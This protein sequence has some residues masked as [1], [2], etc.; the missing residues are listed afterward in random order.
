MS[1]WYSMNPPRRPP[2]KA[3]DSG[4]A[5]LLLCPECGYTVWAEV[6]LPGSS[7]QPGC[8]ITTFNGERR[9]TPLLTVWPRLR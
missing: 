5:Y 2:K 6:P 1:R 7:C 3:L 8:T 9:P 4:H